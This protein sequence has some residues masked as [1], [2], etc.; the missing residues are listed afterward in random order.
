[1]LG[2]SAWFFLPPMVNTSNVLEITTLRIDSRLACY[3]VVET[4]RM[5]PFEKT[6][7]P[8]TPGEVL[9]THGDTTV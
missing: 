9:C 2:F 6:M 7:L 1:M 5:S 8:D 4:E 3:R